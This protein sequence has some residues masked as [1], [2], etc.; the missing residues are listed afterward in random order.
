MRTHLH[1]AGIVV[2]IITTC[3]RI[4][5]SSASDKDDHREKAK[6]VRTC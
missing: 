2:R 6:V 4:S 1:T 5:K 3:E